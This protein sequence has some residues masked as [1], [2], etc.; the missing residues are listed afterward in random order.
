MN[1]Q[2]LLATGLLCLNPVICNRVCHLEILTSNY[3]NIVFMGDINVNLLDYN[4]TNRNRLHNVIITN[5][6]NSF[7][8]FPTRVTDTTATTTVEPLISGYLW[9]GPRPDNDLA[10]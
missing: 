8:D 7:L 6:F 10:E 9:T 4:D 2:V 3:E 1:T 5:G